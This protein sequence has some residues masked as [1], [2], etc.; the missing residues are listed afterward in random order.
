MQELATKLSLR[1]P[2]ALSYLDHESPPIFKH[3]AWA[4]GL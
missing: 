3:S 4:R 2:H 1:Q